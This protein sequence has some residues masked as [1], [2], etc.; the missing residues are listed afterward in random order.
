MTRRNPPIL[1]RTKFP[2]YTTHL[3]PRP[4]PSQALHPPSLPQ[5][6]KSKSKRFHV[7]YTAAIISPSLS[8]ETKPG[9]DMF[10][11]SYLSLTS[12]PPCAYIHS[13][14]IRSKTCKAQISPRQSGPFHAYSRRLGFIP[15]CRKCGFYWLAGC[16]SYCGLGSMSRCASGGEGTRGVKVLVLCECVCFAEVV[17]CG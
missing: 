12:S 10:V 4:I 13:K 6:Q 17:R 3:P 14:H 7:Q 16:L 11:P 9:R 5:P 8:P 2:F 1:P 15:V